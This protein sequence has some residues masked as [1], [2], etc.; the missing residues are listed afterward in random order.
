MRARDP[1]R[2][3]EQGRASESR[4][5]EESVMSDEII[6]GTELR[7]NAIN[8]FIF[9]DQRISCANRFAIPNCDRR[10]QSQIATEV[11][12]NYFR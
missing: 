5:L 12:K 11:N 9:M 3:G 7:K 1:E 4:K 10:D 6:C 8:K 2:E